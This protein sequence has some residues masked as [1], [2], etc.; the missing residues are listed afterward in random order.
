MGAIRRIL[1]ANA[2]RA[3][4]A[5]RVMED[6][7]RFLLDDAP[8]A[9]S[10]K[11]CRHDLVAALAALGDLSPA[12][13]VAGDVGTAIRTTSEETR[14][15]PADVVAAAGARVSEALRALEE[16][17]KLEDPAAARRIERLRYDAYALDAALR[18]R[19]AAPRVPQ[20]RLCA[21]VTEAACRRPFEEVVRGAL[22]GGADC[23]QLREKQLEAGALLD[24]ARLLVALAAGHGAAVVVNDRPDVAL[25]AGAT[26][27]HLGQGDLPCAVAR[28]IVGPGIAIGVSTSRLEEAIAARAAGADYCG[29][30]PMHATATKAKEHIVGAAYLAEYLAWRGLPHLAIGGIDAPRA[31]ALAAIGAEGVAVCAAICGAEDPEAATRTIRAAIDAVAS[32]VAAPAP[33]GG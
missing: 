21:I 14:A 4:E 7:A 33:S 18:S 23:I 24:R 2:N 10:C 27:V 5:L 9:E 25:A 30:G 16:F 19:L 26:A 6:A 29:V 32:P 13:D 3:R 11:R 15:T 22:A 17:A 1:D 20:W 31:A 12:R 8:L 28:R